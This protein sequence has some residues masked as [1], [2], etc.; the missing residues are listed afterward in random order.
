MTKDRDFIESCPI[1]H[2]DTPHGD[3][4][5]NITRELL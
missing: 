5:A 3:L 1:D 4:V 2:K